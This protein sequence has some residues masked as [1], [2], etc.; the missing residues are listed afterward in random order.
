M[1]RRLAMKNN[2]GEIMNKRL[3]L[4]EKH[5]REMIENPD[6]LEKIPDGSAVL[7]GDDKKREIEEIY[8]DIEY[9]FEC[10]KCNV[11]LEWKLPGSAPDLLS[12][13]CPVCYEILLLDR[14]RE[15]VEIHEIEPK[16]KSFF[17]HS[18][19]DEDERVVKFFKSL[20]KMYCVES[21]MVEE[22][23]H[24]IPALEKIEE[25]IR[26][27]D[28]VFAVLTKRYEYKAYGQYGWKASEY[29]QNEIGMAYVYHKPVIAVIEEGVD[30]EGILPDISW[31]HYF[32]RSDLLTSIVMPSEFFERLENTLMYI[33]EEKRKEKAAAIAVIGLTVAFLGGLLAASA[34]IG[35]V[36]RI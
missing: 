33:D 16:Y 36:K 10:P 5:L 3:D 27:S 32:D 28:F 12:T 7:L 15:I 8:Y 17:S 9:H 24:P 2:E 20:L 18:A 1:L 26:N 30:V 4:A 25:G 14:R 19:K 11:K 22:D 23:I 13:F 29:I 35:R 21:Y 6:E 31:Y 34:G